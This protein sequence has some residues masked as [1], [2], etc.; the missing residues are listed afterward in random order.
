[1]KFNNNSNFSVLLEESFRKEFLNK[2]INKF[3]SQTK[4]AEYLNSKIKNRKI[5]RENIKE[6]LKGKH[7]FGWNILIPINV[8]KELCLLNSYNLNEI[9]NKAIKFNPSWKDPNKKQLLV[10][11]KEVKVFK[12]NNNLYLDLATILPEKSLEAQRSRKK[13]PLFTEINKDTIKLWSEACW[14]QS[15]IKS[16]RFLELNNLFFIGSAIFVSEG[17][18]KITK[19]SYNASISLGNSEPSI[20]NIFIKWLDSFLIN[21][22]SAYRIEYNGQDFNENKLKLFWVNKLNKNI[23]SIKVNFRKNY[24]SS[25]INNFGVLNI[26]INIT[27]LKP[28]VL[29]LIESSKKLIF[30]NGGWC[31][32]YLKGL[33]AS[34]G[35]VNVRKV[36]KEVTIGSIKFDERQFIK[37]LLKKLDLNFCE[38]K[39]Q[40][41]IINWNSFYNLFKYDIFEIP[42]INS[43]SKKKRFLEGFKNHEKTKKLIKLLPFKNKKFT[44]N[45]WQKYYNLKFYISSHKYLNPLIK[46]GFLKIKF[47]KN[48]KFFYINPDRFN[49]LEKIWEL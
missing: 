7:I 31:I 48:K 44:A 36:L 33:L 18:T 11:A 45:D 37:K 9:L 22:K 6:W 19:D 16:K 41:T 17:T 14:K 12:K 20:I 8:L 28:F 15:E 21:Y 2:A 47:V 43:Y 3:G 5:I 29:N 25:L 34:E 42:Q 4:L 35:S 46:E 13:L 24:K 26:K 49:E 1:M 32:A 27:I 40:I 38:G 39:N 23:D 30:N 10:K